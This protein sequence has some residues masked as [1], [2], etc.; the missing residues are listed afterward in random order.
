MTSPV[1]GPATAAAMIASRGARPRAARTPPST[2]VS[3]PG[4][5]SP[6]M[7]A[8]SRA[9]TTKTAA[10]A[11]GAG[12]PRNNTMKRFIG[13]FSANRIPQEADAQ[14]RA[15]ARAAEEAEQHE[16]GAVGS[17]AGPGEAEEQPAETGGAK[18]F[19]RAADFVELAGIEGFGR[20]DEEPADDRRHQASCG[21]SE[22]ADA[23]RERRRGAEAAADELLAQS[24][25]H[26]LPELEGAGG[27][28]DDA[29]RLERG[30]TPRPRKEPR[31]RRV[32]RGRT[33]LQAK[34]QGDGH[35]C[36]PAVADGGSERQKPPP[37]R[38]P[39][40]R[41]V[42]ELSQHE[43]SEPNGDAGDDGGTV[44]TAENESQG[45]GEALGPVA[46]AGERDEQGNGAERNV[47]GSESGVAE[48][49][50]QAAEHR[51]LARII[52][53][54]PAETRTGDCA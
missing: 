7:R 14:I 10:T 51:G 9:G 54:H 30:R 29:G 13:E 49:G 47:D 3:S 20:A 42:G 53:G 16:V 52:R 26:A 5:I 28:D 25:A 46:R 12:I 27:D 18:D 19:Q 17:E 38:P 8:V 2:T 15:L 6:R 36:E 23:D 1:I 34:Q 44:R 11:Q 41:G 40:V 50:Q 48:A 22:A 4:I 32:R 24:A 35:P 43:R 37:H 21:Q 33:A 31:Q 45:P 39:V